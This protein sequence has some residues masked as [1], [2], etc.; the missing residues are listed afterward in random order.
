MA[1]FISSKDGRERKTLDKCQGKRF[2]VAFS[3]I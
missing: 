3:P 2:W 1:V